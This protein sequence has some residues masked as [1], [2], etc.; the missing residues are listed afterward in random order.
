MPQ[1]IPTILPEFKHLPAAQCAIFGTYRAFNPSHLNVF[2]EVRYN[3][4]SASVVG[5][6]TIYTVPIG[7]DYGAAADDDDDGS[8]ALLAPS[9]LGASRQT[10]TPMHLATSVHGHHCHKRSFDF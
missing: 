7:M 5:K 3:P 9:L 8:H 1:G 4:V 6:C 2:F 10:C